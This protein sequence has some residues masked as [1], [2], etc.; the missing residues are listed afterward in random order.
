MKLK[1]D[2]PKLQDDEYDVDEAID[3]IGLGR[4]QWFLFCILGLLSFAY[5]LEVM[6]VAFLLPILVTEFGVTPLETTTV[7]MAAIIGAFIGAFTLGKLSDQFGRK[8]IIVIGVC[9][10]AI[11]GLA[12]ALCDDI[13]EESIARF[14]VGF[15]MKVGVVALTLFAEFL[16]NRYRGRILI[17]QGGFWT[18]G[19][20]A[21]VGLAWVSLT[22]WSWRMYVKLSTIPLWI[23][24]I[25]ALFMKESPHY[26]VSADRVEKAKELLIKLSEWNNCDEE[27]KRYLRDGRL[28]PHSDLPEEEQVEEEEERESELGVRNM[29]QDEWR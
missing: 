7:P 25:G 15:F 21:S 6:V 18:L 28:V 14:F 5:A 9:C 3:K 19:M 23:A 27:T 17:L 13:V 2:L 16:P 29:K 22:Y 4:V 10:T 8:L 20:I 12:S 26:L 11:A 24:A 1:R